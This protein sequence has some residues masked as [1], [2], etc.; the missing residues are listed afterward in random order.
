L[1]RELKQRLES[2]R[3][4][5]VDF[6]PAAMFVASAPRL[7]QEPAPLPEPA[8]ERAAPPTASAS[9]EPRPRPATAALFDDP[10][11]VVPIIPP[12]ER[13]GRLEEIR[14]EVAHCVRCPILAST[15]TQTVFGVG[16]PTARIMFIGEAPG[17]DEDRLG[18]PFV[19][20]RGSS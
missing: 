15:R 6:L 1:A 5:G 13:A 2:L 3:R 14:R 8:V 4:A 17:A 9:I 12:A 18:E 10:E 7:A 19:G 11:D 16:S 20:A